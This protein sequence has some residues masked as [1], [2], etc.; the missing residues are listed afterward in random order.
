MPEPIAVLCPRRCGMS[1]AIAHTPRRK[2]PRQNAVARWW[3]RRTLRLSWTLRR[4]RIGRDVEQALLYHWMMR[5]P[6]GLA[7]EEFDE[8]PT[9]G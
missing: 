8:E 5:C 1:I 3:R 7:A 9:D 4:Y 2:P 6:L